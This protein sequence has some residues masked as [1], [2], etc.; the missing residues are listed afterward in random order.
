MVLPACREP[1]TIEV[2]R[3]GAGPFEHAWFPRSIPD[4]TLWVVGRERFEA[5][6]IRG[7]TLEGLLLDP[8]W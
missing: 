5:D 1:T 2:K 3:G 7:R 8:A 6:R 4:A